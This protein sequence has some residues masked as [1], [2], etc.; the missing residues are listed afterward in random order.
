MSQAMVVQP[1]KDHHIS[2]A[3]H[4]QVRVV[5]PHLGVVVAITEGLLLQ[6]QKVAAERI[7]VV[8]ST[9]ILHH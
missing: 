8:I 9:T 6:S 3:H 5:D 4:R 7:V 2:I 1:H